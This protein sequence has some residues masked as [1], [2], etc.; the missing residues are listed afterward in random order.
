MRKLL[1]ISLFSILSI[2]GFSQTGNVNGNLKDTISKKALSL[3][4]VTIFNAK[5]TT[6]V[7]YRLSNDEGVFKIPNLPCDID[8]R[9]VITF[10]GYL[11]YRKEFKLMAD[12]NHIDF[13][14]I[15]MQPSKNDLDEVVVVAERPPV[16]FKKDTIEFNA[17]AFKTLPTALVEDL[18]KKLPGVQ[19][20]KNGDI[21]VNGKKVSRLLV[22]G[23]S[24][25]GDDPKMATRNL[26]ANIIDKVQVVDDKD[27][28]AR[29][30]DGNTAG[31]GK[32]I[33]ITLK[34]TAKKG[35]F[36]KLYAGYGTNERNELGG[37][38]NIYRDTLQLS[39]LG[40]N[41]NINK[42]GFSL[43]EVQSTGGFNR[44]GYNSM[45]MTSN[46]SRQGFALNNISFGG[47]EDGLNT[48]SGLGFN[49]NHAPN[50]KTA[51]SL[52]YFYGQNLTN[53]I[54]T[55]NKQQFIADTLINTRTINNNNKSN[56]S[57]TINIGY[58]T[59][60]DTL[61][62][63]DIKVGYSNS[64]TNEQIASTINNNNNKI[65]RLSIGSGNLL[66]KEINPW[67]HHDISVIRRFKSK[68]GR[69][70]N[71]YH[72][73][74]SRAN[75]NNNQTESINQFY[76]PSASLETFQ[77]LRNNVFPNLN[78]N[79]NIS[80]AEPLTKKLT[81]R[82]G[83]RYNYIFDKQDIKTYN[84]DVNQQY[85]ILNNSLSTGYE[86]KQ[87]RF[88]T[89]ATLSYK[90]KSLTITSGASLLKQNIKNTFNNGSKNIEQKLS[91]IVPNIMIQWKE[92]TLRYNMDVVAP[93]IQYLNSVPDNTNPFYIK[94][95][96]LNL[97]PT[98]RHI[99]NGWGWMQIPKINSN[100]N[101][102]VWGNTVDDDII[103][104]TTIDDKGIVTTSPFNADGTV[105]IGCNIGFN[106]E[107]KKNPKFTFSYGINLW[108][109]IVKKRL[110][111]NS[112]DGK[113]NNFSI[114]PS[115]RVTFNWNDIVE[116]TP[117][118]SRGLR[119]AKY[120]IASMK[121]IDVNTLGSDNELIVRFP[122]KIIWETNVLHDFNDNVP[123]GLPK[124]NTLW[125]AS[126][127]V[128]FLKDDKGQLKFSCFDI[129]NKNNQL[130]TY[131]YANIRYDGQTN[132]LQ[133]YFLL[134][135]TYNIRQMGA[136]KGKIGGK[137]RLFWF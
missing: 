111:V 59:K 80:Y 39:L 53:L 121:N 30:D 123:S 22:D 97:L 25:F 83:L 15:I 2:L 109:N 47:T 99:I 124:Y 28:I 11:P 86:R 107:F 66:S 10:S 37:I 112:I 100:I 24:F 92:F 21:Y 136:K 18:L 43:Q 125:N 94:K 77:Q 119:T 29:S 130:F 98:K 67:Y 1:L 71:F 104:A 57:N 5:D 132:V 134:T 79:S 35:V 6:L 4:T 33:N 93:N 87:N 3:A 69:N 85:T 41:N 106:Q 34:K 74:G 49:L 105:E 65:G 75:S 40:F 110:I 103:N 95:G 76:I 27:A 54:E 16:V 101:F 117:S 19:V 90:I 122:K 81:L 46:G 68:K 114:E 9:M 128:L 89:I 56:Y 113:E 108:S 116:F 131:S 82:F 91:N 60:P 137:D 48:T 78:T 13:G 12:K 102:S 26:P 50:K 44:S 36:G 62:D 14:T 135:F 84:K 96:N 23:K 20:D 129:L 17:S 31:I 52:Q 55:E 61:T 120:T 63:I 126:V 118:I 42:S 38:V 73:L 72:G 8:L 127:S 51:F 32:V 45:M 64:L 115:L 133:Q 70:L 58:K 88:S 7:T